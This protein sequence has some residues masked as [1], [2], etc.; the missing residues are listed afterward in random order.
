MHPQFHTIHSCR[1]TVRD[2]GATIVHRT[3]LTKT[4]CRW[5]ETFLGFLSEW[6]C[7]AKCFNRVARGLSVVTTDNWLARKF[8]GVAKKGKK[9]QGE[10]FNELKGDLSCTGCSL[11]R[12]LKRFSFSSG[13]EESTP[14]ASTLKRFHR[15]WLF[16]PRKPNGLGMVSLDYVSPLSHTYINNSTTN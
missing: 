12:E 10:S 15:V 3:D 1:G 7:C 14:N 4:Y 16:S 11:F 6:V 8:R 2:W 9:V 13:S 5:I